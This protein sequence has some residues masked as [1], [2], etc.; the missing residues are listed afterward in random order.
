MTRRFRSLALSYWTPILVGLVLLGLHL[1]WAIRWEPTKRGEVVTGFG[2]ALIVLGL[3]VASRPYIR[4]GLRALIEESLGPA[5]L[6]F[7]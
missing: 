3:F 7:Q 1:V 5:Q 4:S 2:A 6:P